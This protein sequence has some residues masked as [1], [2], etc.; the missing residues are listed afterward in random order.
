M[1]ALPAPVD[2]SRP[3]EVVSVPAAREL[4]NG[5]PSVGTPRWLW[6]CQGTVAHN[7]GS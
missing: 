4:T 6:A 1:S 2:W 3:A 5:S 7:R